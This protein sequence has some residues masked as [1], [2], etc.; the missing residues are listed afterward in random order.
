MI[1]KRYQLYHEVSIDHQMSIDRMFLVRIDF[2]V[3]TAVVP[4]Q[5]RRLKYYVA[6]FLRGLNDKTKAT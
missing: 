6:E 1:R 2:D 4:Q 5:N 3:W